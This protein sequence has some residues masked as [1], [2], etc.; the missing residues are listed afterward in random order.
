LTV[1]TVGTGEN[2]PLVH[3]WPPESGVF[4]S[5]EHVKR[6]AQVVVLGQTVEKNLFPQNETALGKYVLI[7]SAPFMVI[8]VI[9][10]QRVDAAGDDM[11]NSVWLALHYSRSADIRAALFQ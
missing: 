4:F 10:R 11:D 8:G 1:T 5:A 3:D 2:F 7:G 9:K 6:Y